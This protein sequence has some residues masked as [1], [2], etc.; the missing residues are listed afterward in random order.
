MSAETAS[1]L[2]PA[3]QEFVTE[4]ARRVPAS[5]C[6]MVVTGNGPV[7]LTPEEYRRLFDLAEGQSQ[8]MRELIEARL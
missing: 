7:Y 6:H 8:V 4:L 2:T 5:P 1:V 3:D